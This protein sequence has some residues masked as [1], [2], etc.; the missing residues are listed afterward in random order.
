[1]I[2]VDTSVIIKWLF[3]AEE[4]ATDAFDLYEKHVKEA[5][6]IVVPQILLYEVANVLA[7]KSKIKSETII[8]DINF[9]YKANLTFHQENRDELAE[10]AILAKE[11]KTSVYDM[12]YAVI[13]KNKKCVLVTADENFVKR[14]K[15]KHMQLL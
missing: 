1:M 8:S 3:R 14:T 4:G 15:F 5:E 9:I 10:A 7:T 11:Y 12:L 13:A 6:E 2:V